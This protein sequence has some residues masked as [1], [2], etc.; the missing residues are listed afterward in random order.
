M[1]YNKTNQTVLDSIKYI[2]DNYLVTIIN[3]FGSIL[4]LFSAYIFK[5]I[6]DS[7]IEQRNSSFSSNKRMYQYLFFK[8]ISDSF[9]QIFMILSP[10]YFCEKFL[11]S[12]TLVMNLWYIIFYW[13]IADCLTTV[14]G[15]LEIAATFDCYISINNRIKWIKEKKSFLTILFLI[16]F[17]SF[18]YHLFYFFMLNITK[19]VELNSLNQTITKYSVEYNFK[20]PFKELNYIESFF[21]GFVVLFLLL[22]I[23]LAILIELKKAS[24]RKDEFHSSSIRS[25]SSNTVTNNKVINKRKLCKSAERRKIM[26]IFT[27]FII[28]FIGQTSYVINNFFSS[29][30]LF[31]FSVFLFDFSYS[32]Y[33]FVYLFFNLKF[34]EIFLSII[35]IC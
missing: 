5:K 23:N 33:F 4:N 7:Q 1:N 21:R 34:R 11:I 3:F 15:L 30:Y 6:L 22:I 31:K 9:S 25:V 26:M 2:F 17:L 28:Y 10:F 12:L 32:I 13:F 18:C 20:T 8:S 24:K 16:Y 19:R 29:E 27:I 35:K 14:S